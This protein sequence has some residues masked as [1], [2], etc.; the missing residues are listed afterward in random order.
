MNRREIEK[1]AKD[2]IKQHNARQD[3]KE[4]VEFL[5]WLD[6]I[7]TK[8]ACIVEVGVARGGNL[9]A[10][11]QVAPDPLYIGIDTNISSIEWGP[12]EPPPPQG[13]GIPQIF[14]LPMQ[15]C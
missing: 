10:M 15:A 2:A 4:Y 11:Q 12:F 7:K 3:Y 5:C 14:I 9:W 13:W 1:L 8:L 6:T